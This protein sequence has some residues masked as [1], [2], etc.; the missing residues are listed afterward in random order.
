MKTLI[1]QGRVIDPSQR[2]DQHSDVLINNGKIEAVGKNLT[3]PEYVDEHIDARGL[4]V[5][6]GFVDLSARLREP[7]ETHKAT[8]HSETRAAAKGGITSLLCPPDTT[9][10][11]DN[12]AV[13]ELIIQR[14]EKAAFTR[15]Y[16]IGALTQG[17]K[18]QQLSAM[19]TLKK[20]GCTGMSNAYHAIKNTQV[21]RGCLEYAATH[22]LTVFLYAEDPYLSQNRPFH[23]GAISTRM[24][25]PGMPES[26]ETSV[27]ARDLILIE[28]TG[29]RAHFCRLSSTR[30][31]HM[32]AEAQ[33]RGLTVSADVTAH[34]LHLSDE[35]LYQFNPQ[36]HIRPPVRSPQDRDGLR[37]AL[38]DGTLGAICSDH[39]PHEA[40][41][42]LAPLTLTEAGLSTL[43]TLLPLALD[44]VH[45]KLFTLSDMI[46]RL[47]TQPA[48][49]AGIEGGTLVP[50]KNADICLFDA[51]KTWTV[52]PQTLYSQGK[53][54]LW[55]TVTLHGQVQ[56]TLLAG[57]TVYDADKTL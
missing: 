30:A 18:G 50:G 41:A 11:I 51:E 48:Q 21:L 37:L 3:T 44:L 46:Q 5:C 16:P 32:V 13:A 43:E 49:I 9:P 22:D 29:V 33:A 6:P 7:G 1:T 47:S 52:T 35:I 19:H 53:N 23:E 38:R 36:C 24:G 12:P 2:L 55:Q 17:L 15:V 39:Q 34:H 57:Q 45:E 20:A 10:V 25:L 14:A 28:Q 54:T 56:R 27:L 4:I 8:I 42:K 31:T 40:D 26:A